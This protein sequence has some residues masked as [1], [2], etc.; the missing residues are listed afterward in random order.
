MSYVSKFE[1]RI[2]TEEIGVV[3]AA[4]RGSAT[5]KEGIDA[6]LQALG[7][8]VQFLPDEGPPPMVGSANAAHAKKSD[9]ECAAELE[10]NMPAMNAHAN[11]PKGAGGAVLT[12]ILPIV[13][14]LLQRWLK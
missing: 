7:C 8:G 14:Q 12:I 9:E 1:R 5:K 6:G 2:P 11:D 4:A 13:L 10:A 3:I